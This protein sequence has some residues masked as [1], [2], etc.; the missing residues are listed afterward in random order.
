MEMK[1]GNQKGAPFYIRAAA[2]L[3]RGS[4]PEAR[5]PVDELLLL[6]LGDAIP[7]TA[8]VATRVSADGLGDVGT[9]QTGWTQLPNG[10]TCPQI[11]IQVWRTGLRP[12]VSQARGCPKVELHVHL[13]GSF[14][15]ATMFKAALKFRDQLPEE[16]ICP[17]TD[18]D[19][20]ENPVVRPR[21]ELGD[22][23]T[24]GDYKKMVTTK[25]EAGLY[26]LLAI[27]YRFLPVVAGRNELLEELAFRFCEFQKRNNVIYT[28]VRYSPHEFFEEQHK[29]DPPAGM[30]KAVVEAISRG[31]ARGQKSFGI[32]VRQ[33]LC[34]INFCPHWSMD[35]V[36][37]ALACRQLGVVGIDIASGEHH[38]DTDDLHAGHKAALDVAHREGLP[39]TVHAGEDGPAANVQKAVEVYHARRIG[40][41]YHLLQDQDLYAKLKEAGIHLECCPTSSLLTRAVAKDAG[42]HEHPIA[43]FVKDSMSISINTDDPML[44]N[45]DLNHEFSIVAGKIGLSI[46]D[47]TACVGNAIDAAFCDD[48]LKDILRAQVAALV[49]DY[50]QAVLISTFVAAAA[51]D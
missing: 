23:T 15:Y 47:I 44:F 11:S 41:G 45:V 31:L 51:A 10:R 7:T 3:L 16:R 37:T 49:R 27:F 12:E 34:C 38:F 30:A 13:D 9:V 36:K 2:N 5:E 50:V 19:S 33:I 6:G 39:I 17:W 1:I 42:W 20:G 21:T 40:H 24:L 32:A 14:D 35:T 28:E 26:P 43:K 46:D 22:Q 48:E 4:D 25:A 8:A 18:P 29:K